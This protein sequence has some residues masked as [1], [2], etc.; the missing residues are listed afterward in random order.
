[1]AFGVFQS[2]KMA[3]SG[4]VIHQIDVPIMSGATASLRIKKQKGDKPY[5]VMACLASGNYQYYPM[6]LE[7][8]RLFSSAVLE[9][10]DK[11]EAAFISD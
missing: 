3:M 2:L 1:M 7:T 11:L 8:F 9:T 4:K 6:D 10:R 5:V